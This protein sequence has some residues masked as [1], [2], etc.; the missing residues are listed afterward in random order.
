MT[1]RVAFLTVHTCPLLQPGS[2]WAGGLN[3]YVDE[4]GR[5]LARE[6][7][8]VDVFTRRHSADVPA[9][10]V[11]EDGFTVHHVDAGPPREIGPNRAL[12]FLG[13]FTDS[14]LD[15][16]ESLPDMSLIHSHYWLAG[17]AGLKL[18]AAT[19]LPLVNSFHTLGRVK[20]LNRRADT[21]PSSLL[22]IATE[23]QVIESADR[24]VVSTDTEKE[25]LVSHYGAQ[26]ADVC[27]AVPGVNHDLFTPGIKQTARLRLGW[28]DVP[29]VLFVGRIQPLKGPDVALEAFR[30]VASE[31]ENAR[32]VMV[33]A[34]TGRDGLR[35]FEALQRAA[36]EQDLESSVT[37]AEPVPHDEMPDVYRAS[38]VVLVPSRSE[39]FG[40]VAAEAQ[41]SGIPVVASRTGGLPH[42]VT[43]ELGGI[44]VEGW[45]PEEWADAALRVLQDPA[46]AGRLAAAGALDS[47]RF[48]WDIAVDRILD[49]Y[50]GVT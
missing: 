40:L 35:E 44:L 18:K 9:T 1:L 37:F 15:Q 8:E 10:V 36:K 19:G 25:D 17:W 4:L 3:V 2:G 42:V 20:D 46:L 29:T 21:V 12:R 38:D 28:P 24:I 31:I 27:V 48:S 13:V 47:E 43:S 26:A 22:R 16:L 23:A 7:V 11:V 45:D 39:S 34:P 49:I 14:V 30:H 5:A 32:L 41:A 50:D 6:G 33:G